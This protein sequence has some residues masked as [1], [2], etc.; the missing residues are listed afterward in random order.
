MQAA[1]QYIRAEVSTLAAIAA[2]PLTVA[3]YMR[4]AETTASPNELAEQFAEDLSKVSYH[5]RKLKRLGAIEEIESRPVRGATEHFYR[6]TERP[7]VTDEEWKQLS[8]EER[9]N[10]SRD[11]LQRLVAELSLALETRTFDARHDRVL[12]RHPDLDLDEVGWKELNSLLIEIEERTYGIQ[13]NVHARRA[14]GTST[15]SI[16]TTAAYIQFERISGA[17]GGSNPSK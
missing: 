13:A 14:A 17:N 11:I 10:I 2:H 5:V 16:L 1:D 9:L 4:L 15:G 12:I 7:M 8:I 6:A 3:C